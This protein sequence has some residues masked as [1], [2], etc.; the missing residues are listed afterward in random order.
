MGS[1]KKTVTIQVVNPVKSI[2]LNAKSKSIKAKKSY[3]L[4]ATVLPKNA[5]N[6]KV[7]Y[8][9]SNTKVATVSS[10]GK[11]KAKKKGKATITVTSKSNPKVKTKCKIVVK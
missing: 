2:K 11:I 3:K 10:S 9:S 5:T 1:I 4:K 6:K 8:K 7:T